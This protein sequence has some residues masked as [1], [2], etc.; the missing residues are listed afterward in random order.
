M[1]RLAGVVLGLG[2]EPVL[3]GV[4]F[5]LEPG[6]MVAL[7]GPPGV[8][9]TVVLKIIA[10]LLRPNAGEV[11]VDGQDFAS[12]P[13][14]RLSELRRS[15]GMVF[16]NN[17][18]FD[19]RTIFENV[20]FPLRRSLDPPPEAEIQERVRKRLADVG[21]SGSEALFPHE[22][23][24]GMQKRAGIARATVFGPKIRLYDEP[25]AG[26]DPVTSARIL[27]LIRK[28]HEDD[29][30]GVT[31]VVS[32]EMDTLLRSVP[33]V[34]MLFRGELAFDGPVADLAVEGSAPVLVRQFVSGAVEAEL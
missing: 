3:R 13:E 23:S 9:K 6:A 16:Q 4:D 8:G 7:I 31:V 19:S 33:R 29:P 24:G 25:T 10:G 32:N 20:A 21:L 15:I 18:L 26:L 14:L 1:I 12:L 5:T 28:L 22:L 2:G 11:F 30:G 27:A 17:A 34:L